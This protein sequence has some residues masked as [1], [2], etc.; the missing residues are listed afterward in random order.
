M[1]REGYDLDKLDVYWGT[2]FIQNEVAPVLDSAD[3]TVITYNFQYVPVIP[4]TV[5]GTVYSNDRAQQTFVISTAGHFTFANLGTPTGPIAVGG[6]IDYANNSFALTWDQ[7][8]GKHE[9]VYSYECS[10][11]YNPKEKHECCRAN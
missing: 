4:G 11:E 8:P 3:K 5:T 10:I 2:P 1:R 7:S 9:V 6:D